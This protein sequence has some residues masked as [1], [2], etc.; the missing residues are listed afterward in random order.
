[1]GTFINSV[2]VYEDRI[3]IFYNI[4]GGKQ[5]SPKAILE[6]LENKEN[7]KP[8]QGSDLELLGGGGGIRT[9]EGFHPT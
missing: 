2:Y 4:R 7:S 9:H 1:M 6:T 3:I 8:E 5:I